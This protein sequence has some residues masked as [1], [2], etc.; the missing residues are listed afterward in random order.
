VVRAR[1]G[2]LGIA[3]LLAWT[4]PLSA[5]TLTIAVT[6]DRV[7]VRAPGWSFLSGEALTRLKEGRTV[8]V[9]LAVL[10]LAGP[11]RSP[12]SALRQIFS[13]SYD[14]WEE[15]F[16]VAASGARTA[17]VSH[18]TAAAAEAWCLDQL[19]VPIAA[20]GAVDPQRFWIRVDCRILDFDGT[21]DPDDAGL[22]LQRLI[23]VLSRRHK[24]DAPARTL[25]GGPFRVR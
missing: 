4:A 7:K 12:A 19:A 9:E 18:L 24:A 16:A 10:A 22:T 6:G 2:A 15:R 17:S 8:R 3:A 23:E 25:E 11:G 20:L 14:L 5:Q 1:A 13:V 21:T